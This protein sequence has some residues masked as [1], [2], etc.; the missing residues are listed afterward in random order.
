MPVV[1]AWHPPAGNGVGETRLIYEFCYR[2]PELK[3]D[4]GREGMERSHQNL[5]IWTEAC[6]L[7]LGGR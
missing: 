4:G 7:V 6:K 2:N 1:E 5:K 3:P